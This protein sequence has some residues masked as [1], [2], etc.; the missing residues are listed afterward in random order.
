[1]SF[2][3]YA[4]AARRA[5]IVASVPLFVRRAFLMLGTASRSFWMYC[6]KRG[7]ET[8]SMEPDSSCRITSSATSRLLC[9]RIIAPKPIMKSRTLF[10]STS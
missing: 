9:P 10:P 7:V 4:R 3:V 1:L 8:P 2:P 5:C 6:V